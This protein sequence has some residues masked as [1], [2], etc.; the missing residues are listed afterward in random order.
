MPTRH[1][2]ECDRPA[3]LFPSPAEVRAHPLLRKTVGSCT[4]KSDS[5]NLVVKYGEDITASEA[6]CLRALRRL[7]SNDV[8][9]PEVYGCC[10]DG[11]E[12]F[13]YMELITGVTLESQWESLSDQS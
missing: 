5:L 3:H 1:L 7:L 9:V 4:T 13:I 8:P 12:V 10:E 2:I 11:G 6:H